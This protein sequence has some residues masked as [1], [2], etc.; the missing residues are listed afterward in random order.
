MFWDGCIIVDHHTLA[1]VGI[2][3]AM[4]CILLS[5]FAKRSPRPLESFNKNGFAQS[6]GNHWLTKFFSTEETHL[7]SQLF[8]IIWY[9]QNCFLLSCSQSELVCQCEVLL[10]LSTQTFLVKVAKD[11]QLHYSDWYSSTSFNKGSVSKLFTCTQY[12]ESQF[13]E[14]CQIHHKYKYKYK[15]KYTTN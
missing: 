8:K 3:P 2:K 13:P 6:L 15:Y 9:N 7:S 11:A 5:S 10:S 1:Q 14:L 12:P 4:H